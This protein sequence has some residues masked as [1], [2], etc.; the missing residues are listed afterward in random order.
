MLGT[1]VAVSLSPFQ[2]SDL[3]PGAKSYD[4]VMK[5]PDSPLTDGGVASISIMI[6]NQWLTVQDSGSVSFSGPSLHSC[7]LRGRSQEEGGCAGE[8]SL[9]I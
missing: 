2:P 6:K 7:P 9:R 4:L 3:A 1:D 5:T 8:R